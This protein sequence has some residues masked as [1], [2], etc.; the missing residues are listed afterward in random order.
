MLRLLHSRTTTTQAFGNTFVLLEIKDSDI[1]VIAKDTCNRNLWNAQQSATIK[2]G[3]TRAIIWAGEISK[4][5][6]LC[7]SVEINQKTKKQ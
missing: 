3:A 5:P 6:P 2:P 4:A 7:A 1:V